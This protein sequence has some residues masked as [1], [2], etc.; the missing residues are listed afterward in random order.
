[1]PQPM[2]VS[3]PE[4]FDLSDGMQVVVTAVDP[5]TNATVAGVTISGVSLSVDPAPADAGDVKFTA[6]PPYTQGDLAA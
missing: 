6:L 2:I 3:L 4:F 1:M 5:T